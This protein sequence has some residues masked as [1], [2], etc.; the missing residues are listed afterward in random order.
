MAS[1]AIEKRFFGLNN[2]SQTK[3]EAIIKVKKIALNLF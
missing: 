2:C 3:F 1:N